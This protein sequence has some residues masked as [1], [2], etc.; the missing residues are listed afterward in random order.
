MC[1][2]MIFLLLSIAQ[3]RLVSKEQ[4]KEYKLV[5]LMLRYIRRKLKTDAYSLYDLIVL[6]D[7]Y[8]YIFIHFS[9]YQELELLLLFS[10]AFIKE[11]DEPGR[12]ESLRLA[13]VLDSRY[14]E[15]LAQL[16]RA[17]NYYFVN[18]DGAHW[19]KNRMEYQLMIQTLESLWL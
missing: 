8:H 2:K 5:D 19:L 11:N 3:C 13:S 17:S 1:L 14:E 18:P 7:V 9:D 4:A 12:I 6:F 10:S 16:V 15:D